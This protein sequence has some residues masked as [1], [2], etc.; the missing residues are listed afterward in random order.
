MPKYTIEIAITIPGKA[1]A[2]Y[3]EP[4]RICDVLPR[5]RAERS[6]MGSATSAVTTDATMP[7]PNEVAIELN[8]TSHCTS[9]FE[10]NPVQ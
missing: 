2:T 9:V 8:T 4:S 10:S 1:C 6:A 5:N 3:V 7:I